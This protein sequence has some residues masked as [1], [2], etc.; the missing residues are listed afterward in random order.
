VTELSVGRRGGGASE[1]PWRFPGRSFHALLDRRLCY[2]RPC[3]A[4]EA[5]FV[6]DGTRL[7]PRSPRIAG[8]TGPLARPP[9]QHRRSK[10]PDAET[11]PSPNL[12]A[13]PA[14]V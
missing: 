12:G 1:G 7:T 2:R 8:C 13:P 5:W 6:L 9:P 14:E 11:D 10:N 4:F 3:R